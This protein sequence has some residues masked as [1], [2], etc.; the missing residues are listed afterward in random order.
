MS[1]SNVSV[2]SISGMISSNTSGLFL[3]ERSICSVV[4][5]VATSRGYKLHTLYHQYGS[6]SILNLV[7]DA[8]DRAILVERVLVTMD[9]K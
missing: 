4:V 5:V 6:S 1:S 9:R 2:M 3:K 7:F 8:M